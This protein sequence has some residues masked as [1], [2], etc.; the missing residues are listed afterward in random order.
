[1]AIDLIPLFEMYI[2]LDKGV[3]AFDLFGH[4]AVCNGCC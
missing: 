3:T 4:N 1:M 2:L